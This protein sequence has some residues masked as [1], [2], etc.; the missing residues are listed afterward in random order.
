MAR[1]Q[2]IALLLA[3]ITLVVYLP[4]GRHDFIVFDDPDYVTENRIVQSGITA[5]G[6]GWAFTSF[7][8]SN[9]HPV[10]WLSHMLDCGLFGLNPGAQHIV[11]ALIHAVNAVLVFVLLLQLTNQLWPAAIV[12][13]LFA[14]HPLHVE[15]VAWISE[16]KD[17]LSLLFG[18]LCLLAYTKQVKEHLA[19]RRKDKSPPLTTSYWLALLC[20][21]VGLMA[22]PMLV[23]LPFV[24]LLLD[25]WPLER[26]NAANQ[27]A[28]IQRL[29]LEKAPFFMLAVVS[30]I[31][32]VLAQRS[33]AIVALENVPLELRLK[34]AVVAGGRYLLK[35]IWPS[36]LA[37]I[38]PLPKEVPLINVAI[39]LAFL[40][41]ITF[42]AWRWR[43]PKPHLFIGWLWFIGTLVPVI[44]IVQVGGQAMADRY[45][46]LPHIG[47]FIA[48][49]FEVASWTTKSATKVKAA[50]AIAGVAA[51]ACLAA[52]T[53]QLSYWKDSEILFTHTLAVTLDN[54]V[55]HLNLGL[56]L[57]QQGRLADARRQYEAAARLDPNRVQAQVNL[58]NVLD[59]SGET[60]TA[61]E[62]YRMALQLNQN[63]ALV[64]INYGSALVKRGRFDEAKLHYEEAGRLAAN[65]PRPPYLLG[66][67]LLRQGRSLEAVSQFKEALRIDPNH[68]QTLVWFARTRAADLDP[69]AR[70]GSEA[71]NLATQAVALTGES[72]PFVLDTLAA[73]LAESGRFV[74]A[75]QTLQQALQLLSSAGDTNTATL[76]A[77]LQLYRLKQP[78]RESFTNAAGGNPGER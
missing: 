14:W 65:D 27:R 78:Y 10:T 1:P 40:T 11:N 15:S 70:H 4:A 35:T 76:T 61:L 16:R 38:Y 46:Y 22:K 50:A 77:R 36:D 41:G 39:A 51:L 33:E 57:E 53:R 19:S 3:L 67:A 18:L 13:A 62:H 9:W 31:L 63:S 72:D 12:A 58:A 32:T 47:L 45:T 20:F 69:Q 66:K 37:I 8:A 29:L 71:V 42:V 75:E 26:F 43:K 73:A 24:M 23:T 17:V 48:L 74:E 64:H 52:T 44:G 7:H 34:N 55:A 28:S 68:L 54:P 5:K 2:I 56:A 49:V 30:C 60:E 6:T 25:W 21:A 59:L